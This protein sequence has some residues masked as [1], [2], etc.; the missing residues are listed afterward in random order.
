MHDHQENDFSL[1]VQLSFGIHHKTDCT[2]PL[3]DHHQEEQCPLL[4]S[5]LTLLLEVVETK[6]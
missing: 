4:H 1:L 3:P 5:E 6:W 2:I